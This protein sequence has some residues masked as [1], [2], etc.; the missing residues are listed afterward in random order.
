MSILIYLDNE[1]K[2]FS[3][4]TVN[5]TTIL[6]KT[7]E[8]TDK[9]LNLAQ[10]FEFVWADMVSEGLLNDVN[11]IVYLIGDQ[12]GFTDTRIVFI[13][14]QSWKMFEGGVKEFW[15][16][17]I[18]TRLSDNKDLSDNLR[19]LYSEA[20]S[21]NNHALTYSQEPRIGKKSGTTP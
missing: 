15:I 11:E 4:D 18:N 14:L 6:I 13:W 9:T 5:W 20:I 3:V 10:R 8:R 12:A 1:L 21:K 19:E 17:K 16:N 7:L 2:V